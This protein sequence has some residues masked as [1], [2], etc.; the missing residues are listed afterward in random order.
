MNKLRLREWQTLFAKKM[1]GAQI[2][3]NSSGDSTLAA[4]ERLHRNGELQDYSIEEL[5]TIDVTVLWRK[6]VDFERCS[7]EATM[8]QPDGERLLVS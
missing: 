5:T 2:L 6:P 1:P 8:S 3:T 4:A 7:S